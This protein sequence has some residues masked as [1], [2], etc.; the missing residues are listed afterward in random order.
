MTDGKRN[1]SEFLGRYNGDDGRTLT[2]VGCWPIG[3]NFGAAQVLMHF[4]VFRAFRSQKRFQIADYVLEVNRRDS[5]QEV[6]YS[7]DPQE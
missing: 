2:C 1:H 3:K 6:R 5:Y 7:Y 4:S